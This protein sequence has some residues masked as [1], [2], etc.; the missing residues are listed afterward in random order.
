MTH[1]DIEAAEGLDGLVDEGLDVLLLGD[2]ALDRN[3]LR[4]GEA[5]LDLLSGLL[6]SLGVDVGHD[7]L[8]ALSGE[9]ERGLETDA[10]G[11]QHMH[12]ELGVDGSGKFGS[13]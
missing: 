7:D 4:R 13:D 11:C 6:D 8:G 1:H 9:L 2:V 12:S 3:G 10:A 5:G